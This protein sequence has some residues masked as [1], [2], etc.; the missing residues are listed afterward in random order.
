VHEKAYGGS[1]VHAAVEGE[2]IRRR[3]SGSP[4]QQSRIRRLGAKGESSCPIGA[5][6]PVGKAVGEGE[7][8]VGRVGR[9]IAKK[10]GMG[11]ISGLRQIEGGRGEGESS[12]ETAIESRRERDLDS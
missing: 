8:V 4:C 11:L 5:L 10:G 12:G 3:K 2:K 1:G 9:G 6:S 7:S